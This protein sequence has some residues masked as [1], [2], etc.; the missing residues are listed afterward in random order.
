MIKPDPKNAEGT[1]EILEGFPCQ[2]RTILPCFT[3][4]RI[5]S[6]LPQ[7]TK[8]LKHPIIDFMRFFHLKNLLGML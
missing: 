7:N 1:F 3:T 6:T 5:Q 4:F 8:L 2:C